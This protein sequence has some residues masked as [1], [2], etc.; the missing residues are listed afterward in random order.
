MKKTKIIGIVTALTLSA[1][2]AVAQTSPAGGPSTAAPAKVF[3]SVSGGAQTQSRIIDSTFTLPVYGQTATAN[4]AVGID[5]SSIF[6]LN[7]E[8]RFMKNLG[9]GVGFSTFS[10]TG[11]LTGLASVPHPSF[12]NR[13]ASVTIP[14]QDAKRS[15]RS[16]YLTIV[17]SYRVTEELEVAVYAGPSF[18]NVEQDLPTGIAVPAGTQNITTTVEKQSADVVGGIFGVDVSYFVMRQFGV[19]G[20]LRYNG[21]SVDLPSAENSKVGGFQVGAG[22]R[23]RF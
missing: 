22:A 8:Y 9:V 11:P 4:T 18:L 16:V 3:L 20:F 17:G 21:G 14:E 5:G 10:V 12:F 19:G 1:A 23:I 7:A 13:H 2:T 6:D 15:E